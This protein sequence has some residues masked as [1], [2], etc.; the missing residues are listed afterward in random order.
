MKVVSVVCSGIQSSS[1]LVGSGGNVLTGKGYE[2]FSGVSLYLLVC[3]V[4]I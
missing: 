4:A 1:S 2:L 3:I